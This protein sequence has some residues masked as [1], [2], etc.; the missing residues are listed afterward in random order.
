M[1]EPAQNVKR[2][3]ILCKSI[4]KNCLLLC[5]SLGGNLDFPKKRRFIALTTEQRQNESKLCKLQ[6]G[7]ISQNCG[8]KSAV[9]NV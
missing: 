3:L 8:K 5:F 7:G 6:N 4:H 9:E 2:M 1:P